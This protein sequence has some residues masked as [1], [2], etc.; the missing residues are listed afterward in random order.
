MHPPG[1]RKATMSSR[2]TAGETVCSITSGLEAG[3]QAEFARRSSRIGERVEVGDVG[4]AVRRHARSE[5]ARAGAVVQDVDVA[6]GAEAFRQQRGDVVRADVGVFG[7][8]PRVVRVVDVGGEVLWGPVVEKTGEDEAAV[9]AAA[10]LDVDAGEAEG[11]A[12]RRRAVFVEIDA[13]EG[14]GEAATELAWLA[15]A[16]DRPLINPEGVCDHVEVGTQRGHGSS[17]DVASGRIS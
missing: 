6:P 13:V 7:I 14:T 5:G 11:E 8:D 16:L 15:L 3:D 9:L 2:Q 17:M 1:P 12:V 4:E 10:V